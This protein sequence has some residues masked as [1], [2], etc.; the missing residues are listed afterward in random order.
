[1][2]CPAC[3]DT[4]YRVAYD[5]EHHMSG[6]AICNCEAGQDERRTLLRI[7]EREKERK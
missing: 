3:H 7:Q 2:I 1:M 6:M 4:G 5:A